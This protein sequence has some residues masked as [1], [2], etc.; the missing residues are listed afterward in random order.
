MFEKRLCYHLM[1][2]A[3]KCRGS[4]PYEYTTYMGKKCI[5]FRGT[6]TWYEVV[7]DL[8]VSKTM[9]PFASGNVHTGFL[10]AYLKVKET[11]NGKEARTK[12]VT[13]AGGYSLGAA[14]SVLYAADYDTVRDL[15]L[16]ASPRVGDEDF[17]QDL[18]KKIRKR[19]GNIW[20]L[21]NENDIVTRLPPRPFYA[22][23]GTKFRVNFEKGSVIQNHYLPNYM[24]V[25][26]NEN[27]LYPWS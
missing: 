18:E 3:N 23:L 26:R 2:T 9:C 20:R 16:F 10:D 15:Y 1:D 12:H 14:I 17:T 5:S 11:M 13:V 7:N 24:H 6:S 21:Q 25:F 27:L 22:H 8:K 19:G 4:I